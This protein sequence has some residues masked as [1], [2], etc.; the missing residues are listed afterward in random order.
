MKL[1]TLNYT[2]DEAI[3]YQRLVKQVFFQTKFAFLRIHRGL[4]EN[5]MHL[6]ISP[7]HGGKSTAVRSVL[8]D[9]VLNNRDK[10]V[11][12]ILSEETVEEFKIEFSKTFPSHDILDNVTIMSEQDGAISVSELKKII[13]GAINASKCDLLFYDNITTSTLY[14]DDFKTQEASALWLKALSKT[15]T[16]FLIAH[17]NENSGANKL[18]TE[19]DIRGSKKLPN[20]VE[21]LYVLQPIMVGNKMFQFINIRKHRGQE[22][23]NKL[24]RLYYN[25]ELSTFDRDQAVSFD[26]VKE[27]FKMRNKLSEK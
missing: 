24:F 21:F 13:N 1:E 16:L 4:R 27:V 18:L 23:D 10:Q 26:D 11:L 8:F 5:K 12:I 22:T 25:P 20:L 15:V 7:T 6:L 2:N 17:T 14:P 3:G 9:V 19:S